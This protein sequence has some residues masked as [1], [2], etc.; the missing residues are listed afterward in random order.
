MK[1]YAKPFTVK[2]RLSVKVSSI[3][4]QLA[5]SKQSSILE[6]CGKVFAKTEVVIF[7]QKTLFL[8]KKYTQGLRAIPDSFTQTYKVWF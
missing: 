6:V 3:E 2:G 8:V 4:V 5:S 7:V 1:Y